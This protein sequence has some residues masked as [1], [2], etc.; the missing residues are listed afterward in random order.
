M[1]AICARGNPWRRKPPIRRSSRILRAS[2]HLPQIADETCRR[3]LFEAIDRATRRVYCAIQP[4]KS[5]TVAKAFLK[6]LYR[7]CPIKI[8]RLLSDSD[9]VACSAPQTDSRAARMRST[10]GYRA[11]LDQTGDSAN[12][13]HGRALQ[14]LHQRHPADASIPFRGGLAGD[15]A[16]RRLPVQPLVTSIDFGQSGARASDENALF[17][18]PTPFIVNQIISRNVTPGTRPP[19]GPLQEAPELCNPCNRTPSSWRR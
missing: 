12:Q 1:W 16:A 3:Y 19:F 10:S 17:Q 8:A 13:R 9:K 14:W 18:T 11:S 6:V 4:N 5:A 2:K 7:E 15:L